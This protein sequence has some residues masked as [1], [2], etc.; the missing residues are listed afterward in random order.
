MQHDKE[1]SFTFGVIADIHL[2]N[3]GK[4]GTERPLGQVLRYYRE[5]DIKALIVCGDIADEGG[6]ASYERFNRIFSSVYPNPME[7]PAKIL[8]MGNHDYRAM[9][10][11]PLDVSGVQRRFSESLGVDPD[12]HTVIG[13]CHF[14]GLSGEG[15]EL[16]G[17]FT[18]RSIEWLREQLESAKAD[19]PDRPI[20][21]AVH[22]PVRDTIYGSDLWGNPALDSLLSG[23]PQVI[24]FTGHS[25]YPLACERSIFQKN[26]TAVGLPSLYY[27][28]VETGVPDDAFHTPEALL[29]IV[30]PE[31]VRF[32]RLRVNPIEKIKEDWVLP[33]PLSK[34]GFL[35]TKSKGENRRPPVFP[36]GATIRIHE[37]TPDSCLISFPSAV[38]DDYTHGYIVTVRNQETGTL[39][40]RRH[41]CSDFYLG[42]S[43]MAKTQTV[44]I[45]SLVPDTI[46]RVEIVAVESFGKTS[47]PLTAL[48]AMPDTPSR[49]SLSRADILDC[50]YA[51]GISDRSPSR[52]SCRLSGNP[53]FGKKEN[54]RVLLLDGRSA[55][56]YL[57]AA[58]FPSS[59]FK[60]STSFTLEIAIS[61]ERGDGG[62][63]FTCGD[64][65]IRTDKNGD[66]FLI[67]GNLC[68]GI[69][70]SSELQNRHHMM[71]SFQNGQLQVW[72]NGNPAWTVSLPEPPAFVPSPA[73]SI[74]PSFRGEL[75]LVRIFNAALEE[76]EIKRAYTRFQQA[77]LYRE[78]GR[79]RIQI[80]SLLDALPAADS[81]TD[82]LRLS[83]TKAARTAREWDDK[84]ALT[85]ESADAFLTESAALLHEIRNRYSN[86]VSLLVDDMNPGFSRTV[87]L[88]EGWQYEKNRETGKNLYNK[89]GN[90]AL[91]YLI[92]QA[93]GEITSFQL[94]LLTAGGFGD[95]VR[96]VRIR[97]SPDRIHWTEAA[98]SCSIPTPCPPAMYW[99]AFSLTPDKA[100]AEGMRYLKI[101]LLPFPEGCPVWAV[102]L[103]RLTIESRAGF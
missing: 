85:K 20:F 57:S 38:H 95:P 50:D 23:Y 76:E 78:V 101:E 45:S 59:P 69:P 11:E 56:T 60:P 30:R 31:E 7:A 87:A 39:F 98:T 53:R 21:V 77:S 33:L 15:G 43:N 97:L 80:E 89:R 47:E 9:N 83:L 71:A 44:R 26:Y 73:F 55:V 42:L 32:E 35:Y 52:L 66:V 3:D 13:G 92:Y 103:N 17:T 10:H 1:S 54:E 46:F 41:F 91:Q 64:I 22:Q 102:S 58:S 63:L 14:I 86:S 37:E 5:Q 74:G 67:V 79:R 68:K 28:V 82:R 96:D 61:M 99:N 48:L 62:T 18:E 75:A 93:E 12:P 34:A 100:A 40:F 4:N 81:G 16:N 27:T 88:S 36:V 70:L 90:N 24:L 94:D 19:A 72:I 84:A 2:T 49:R 65:A 25:H 51:A 6:L 29:A 8:V